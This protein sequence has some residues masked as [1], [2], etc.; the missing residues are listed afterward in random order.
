MKEFERIEAEAEP[1]ELPALEHI[2]DDDKEATEA[3]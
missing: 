1:A 2:T 3:A